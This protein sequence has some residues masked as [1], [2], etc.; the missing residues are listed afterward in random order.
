MI[1]IQNKDKHVKYEEFLYLY[2]YYC[3]INKFNDKKEH[4]IFQLSTETLTKNHSNITMECLNN[5]LVTIIEEKYI[6]LWDL[7][8]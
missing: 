5:E 1:G 3:K 7:K 8:L 6:L 2:K 4:N